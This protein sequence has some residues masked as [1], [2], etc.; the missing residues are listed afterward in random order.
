MVLHLCKTLDPDGDVSGG[1]W[2]IF[3][4]IETPSSSGSTSTSP[5]QKKSPKS[6]ELNFARQFTGPVKCE[7]YLEVTPRMYDSSIANEVAKVIYAVQPK[8]LTVGTAEALLLGY[9]RDQYRF[10]SDGIGCSYWVVTVIADLENAGFL[11][12]GTR[13]HAEAF[14]VANGPK[15]K[16]PAMVSKGTFY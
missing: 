3:L 12:K 15:T 1:H 6:V 13:E 9:K 8:Q 7:G 11:P 2:R 14:I 10:N 4:G 16:L 5:Q